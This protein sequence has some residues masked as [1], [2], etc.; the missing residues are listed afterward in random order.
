[1]LN[2]KAKM[3]P[4]NGTVL[5][6]MGRYVTLHSKRRVKQMKSACAIVADLFNATI[7]SVGLERKTSFCL[8]PPYIRSPPGVL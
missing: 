1:M 8:R 6:D 3:N 7:L 2:D 4:V 5:G